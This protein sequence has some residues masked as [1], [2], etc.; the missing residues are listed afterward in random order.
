MR[1]PRLPRGFLRAIV[2]FEDRGAIIGDLDEEFRN[3]AHSGHAPAIRWY[4]GQ[5]LASV[6]GAAALAA[7]GDLR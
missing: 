6:R 5:A 7:R 2:P 1:P 3:R 4:W